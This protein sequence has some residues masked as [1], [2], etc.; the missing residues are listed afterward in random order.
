[1][2][3]GLLIDEDSNGH[4]DKFNNSETGKETVLGEKDGIYLIDSDNDGEWDYIYSKDEGLSEYS[5]S[6]KNQDAPGFELLTVLFVITLIMIWK[7][8]K[9]VF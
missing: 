3:N 6:G 7:R 2:I 5:E 9:V 1:M 4:Y 8:K